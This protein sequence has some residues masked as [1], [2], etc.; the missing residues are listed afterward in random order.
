MR[1]CEAHKEKSVLSLV[2]RFDPGEE[3]D[4]CPECVEVFQLMVSGDFF[5]VPEG[6]TKRRPGRPPKGE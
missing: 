4:L 2:N 3:W 1:V 5:K 6:E